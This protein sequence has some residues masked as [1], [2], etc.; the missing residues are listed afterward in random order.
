MKKLNTRCPLQDECERTCKFVHQER[1]C[2]YYF[3]NSRPGLEIEDQNGPAAAVEKASPPADVADIQL[4]P[5]GLV[6]IDINKIEPHPDNP[7]KDLGD[8]T[9]LAES[10]KTNGVLQNLTVVPWFSEI[11]GVGCDDPKQQE[12]MGYRVVIGHRRLAAAKLAGLTEVPCVISNMKL[13]E[14]VATMLLENMQR[15]DLTVYEQAQG[16]Q[17]MLNLGDSVND[18]ASRTGFSET[19]VRRRVKLLDLD[20]NKFKESTKRGGTLQDYMELDK[21]KSTDRKNA[22]LDKI[23]TPNFQ[24]ELKRAIDEEAQEARTAEWIEALSAFATQ[25]DSTDGYRNVGYYYASSKPDVER[26]EDA[27][28]T[29]YFFNVGKYGSIYLM[30]K[31]SA[32][33]PQENPEERKKKERLEFRRTKLKE[34][35]ERAFN[36]R[37]EFVQNVTASTI[38]KH[39]AEITAFSAM[40]KIES[41]ANLDDDRFLEFLG[42]EFGE[43]EELTYD[44]V[45]EAVSKAPER[46]LLMMLY[47][48]SDDDGNEGYFQYY[49]AEHTENESLDRLYDLLEKLGYEMSDEERALRDG[50]HELFHETTEE[51]HDE[52]QAD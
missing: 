45:S 44:M 34:A 47:C 7:R 49:D 26:P 16:F 2:D 21:I 46:S 36:L 30:K 28:T 4:A 3:A 12:E 19:T 32:A 25:V 39:I 43:D 52:E 5:K 33:A 1:N 35:T 37:K 40:E 50:T 42:I 15:S 29:E 20:Q 17:M 38:K 11:T 10:I 9:E 14:Q 13:R 48:E 18:I 6:L 31:E 41:Y 8:L 27:D 51:N 23:G 22:V 24:N